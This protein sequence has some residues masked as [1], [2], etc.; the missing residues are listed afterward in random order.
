MA[1]P[2]PVGVRS[3]LHAGLSGLTFFFWDMVGVPL[4]MQ[5]QEST[6]PE[7]RD[8]ALVVEYGATGRVNTVLRERVEAPAS[9]EIERCPASP[10][11]DRSTTS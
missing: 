8:Y 3:I 11:A 10:K 2:T 6:K 1:D 9:H 5:F 4:E 7:P